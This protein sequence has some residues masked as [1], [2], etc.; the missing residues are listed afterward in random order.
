MLLIWVT[1]LVQEVNSKHSRCKQI[2][3]KIFAATRSVACS[4]L[5]LE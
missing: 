2:L 3:I 4:Y 1:G 5:C